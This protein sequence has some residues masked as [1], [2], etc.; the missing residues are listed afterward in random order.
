ME[1]YVYLLLGVLFHKESAANLFYWCISA[2]IIVGGLQAFSNNCSVSTM[3][4]DVVY[5]LN[6]AIA[7]VI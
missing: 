6:I 7:I 2:D 3:K 4:C 1:L 5:G